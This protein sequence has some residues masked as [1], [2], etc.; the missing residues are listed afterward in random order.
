MENEALARKTDHW[1]D[2]LPDNSLKFFEKSKS[3]NRT[4]TLKIC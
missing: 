1:R 3:Q 4:E 2:E